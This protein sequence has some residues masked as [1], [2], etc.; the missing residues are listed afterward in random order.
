MTLIELGKLTKG[1]SK[2]INNAS[3]LDKNK[4]LTEIARLLA[5]HTPAILDANAKDIKLAKAH[6][7]SE[8]LLDRMCLT[9]DRIQ[10]MIIGIEQIIALDDPIGEISTMKTSPNGLQI[11]NMCVS[12]GVVGMIYEARPNVTIDAATLCIKSGNAIMLRGSKDIFHSNKV[13]V[14]LMKEALINC[15]FN[16]HI[17]SF[18]EDNSHEVAH[19]FMRLNQYL[20]VLIPRGGK[21]LIQTCVQESSVPL[22]E[23][24]TGNC[25]VYVDIDADLESACNIII[26]AKTSRTSVCNACESVLFHEQI[27]DSFIQKVLCELKKHDVKLHGDKYICSLDQDC[28]LASDQDYAQE[29]LALEISLKRVSNVQAA[30]D[31]INTFSTH[32]SET[33]VSQNYTTI[34]KFIREVDSACVYANAST[35]FSDGFEFGLG[36][37]IG[38]STQ[39]LHA[40]GPMGLK[41]LTTQKYIILGDGQIRT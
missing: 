33:I 1:A 30:I 31:H 28:I 32:H 13:L 40:R 6:H 29:Y 20:D 27:A 23:T 15:A 8:G 4:I 16:E 26:N 39:K 17:I 10:N 22:L 21:S 14:S 25:H 18:V 37:E 9:K 36:A 12:L 35:R 11:G 38:I 19:E 41:A 34:K 5:V 2:Q 24:G 3:S 7:M